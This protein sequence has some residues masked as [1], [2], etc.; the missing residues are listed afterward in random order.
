MAA[1][2]TADPKTIAAAIAAELR[3]TPEHWMQGHL[4]RFENGKVEDDDDYA[5]CSDA[6][7]WCLEGLIVKHAKGDSL[8]REDTYDAFRKI[9]GT[10][11]LHRWND[12]PYRTVNDVI[13]ACE[14]V[15]A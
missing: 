13:E 10:E 11:K 1:N 6:V 8:L 2:P 7:C 5:T 14:K 12:D 15:T 3:A 9:V 4:V